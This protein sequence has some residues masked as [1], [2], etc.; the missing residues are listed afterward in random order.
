MIKSAAV[1]FFNNLSFRKKLLLSYVVV[2]LVPYFLFSVLLMLKTNQQLT[3]SARYS[4][5]SSFDASSGA[6]AQTI[7]RVENAME[8]LGSDW[9]IAN[10][11]T[12]YYDSYY[13]KYVDVTDY[14]DSFLQAVTLTNPELEQI[15]FYVPNNMADTRLSIKPLAEFQQ[16]ETFQA[17]DGGIGIRWLYKSGYF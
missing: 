11:L 4:F 3:E 17:I 5:A 7:D 16:T 10:T 6:A 9:K 12:V 15:N 1:R 14:F 8:V 13:D 2:G